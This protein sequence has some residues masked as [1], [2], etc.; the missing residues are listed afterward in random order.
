M[1]TATLK[2]AFGICVIGLA[3]LLIVL[4]G[5]QHSTMTTESG[6][7]SGR[8]PASFN[9]NLARE[10]SFLATIAID[11]EPA[12]FRA[13]YLDRLLEIYYRS[14]LYLEEFEGHLDR[15]IE[16]QK[17]NPHY[18]ENVLDNEIYMLIGKAYPVS[19]M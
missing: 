11:A 6:S 15:A 7:D 14:E 4:P 19:Q 2:C 16:K 1:L 10:N 9:D 5:C 13:S 3:A 17:S 18:R 12:T 8:M